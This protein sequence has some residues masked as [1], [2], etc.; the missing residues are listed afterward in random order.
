MEN[1]R[2]LGWDQNF[3]S[4]E[5]VPFD[6]LMNRRAKRSQTTWLLQQR[7]RLIRRLQSVQNAAAR[8]MYSI[9]QSEHITDTL[10]SLH[11]LRV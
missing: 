2:N 5:P 7:A 6:I 8:L 10:I 3:S 9:R 11:W 1:F 4:D